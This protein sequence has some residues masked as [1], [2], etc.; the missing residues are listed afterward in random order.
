MSDVSCVGCV[1]FGRQ[2]IGRPKNWRDPIGGV[3]FVPCVAF[4]GETFVEDVSGPFGG[5]KSGREH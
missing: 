2:T 1:S 5:I 4:G 3:P